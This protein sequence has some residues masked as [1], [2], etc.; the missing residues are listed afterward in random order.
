MAVQLEND[1]DRLS[2]ALA[3]NIAT[4]VQQMPLELNWALVGDAL[5]DLFKGAEPLLSQEEYASEMGKLQS[6]LQAKQSEGASEGEKKF[7]AE[8]GAKPGVVT[9]ASGLQYEVLKEGSGAKPGHSDTVRVHYEGRLLDGTVFDSS[10]RRGEPAEFPV[11]RVISGW[12]EALQLMT[13]GSKYRLFIPAALGYGSHGAGDAIPPN[14][15]LIFD[16]ELLN[17]VR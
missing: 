11:N 12:T 14:A 9:T 17:V 8:N 10:I 13:P 5:A 2:Y 1:R 16:V 3:L 4:S 15:T 7:M 6:A